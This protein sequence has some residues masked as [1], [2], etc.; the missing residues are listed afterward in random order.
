VSGCSRIRGNEG[1]SL[2][3]S[4]IPLCGFAIAERE[5]SYPKIAS[6]AGTDTERLVKDAVF[7]LPEQ[8][9][10]FRAAVHE[11]IAQVDPDELIE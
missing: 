8:D 5:R 6:N 2:P 11:G 7:R 3:N 1:C 9:V 4:L 10:H